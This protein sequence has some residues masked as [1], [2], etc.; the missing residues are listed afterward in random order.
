LEDD[1]EGDGDPD[2][3]AV[4]GHGAARLGVRATVA[5]LARGRS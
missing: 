2:R 1:R 4:N 5:R 3:L